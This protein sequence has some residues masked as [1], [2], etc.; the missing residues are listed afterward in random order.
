M[1]LPVANVQG[2]HARCAELQENVREPAGG[3]ADVEAVAPGRVDAE[4]VERMRELLAA[5]RDEARPS[6]DLE[7]G[8]LVHL[9]AGLLVPGNEA[10]EDERLRLRAAL[11]E[12]PFDEQDVQPLL[13][14]A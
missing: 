10:C 12:A 11:R 8:R 9:L 4:G 5:T 2:D 3:G 7:L 6:L 1:Q 13:C 14:H